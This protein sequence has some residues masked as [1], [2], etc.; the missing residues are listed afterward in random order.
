MRPLRLLSTALLPILATVAIEPAARACGCFTP[1]DPTVPIVQAGE[2]IVFAVSQSQVTAIIQIQYAGDAKDFGWLLPLPSLPTLEVSS[3][4]VFARIAGATAPSY[5]LE[6]DYQDQSCFFQNVDDGAPPGL[7]GGGGANGGEMSP[8][9]FQ[10]SVGPYDFAVLKADDK[11]AMLDWLSTNRYFVPVGT[12]D[13]V[14]PYLHAGAYFLALKL[15]SGQST[16]DLQPVVVRY[17][18]DLP[19][20]PI[21]LTSVTASPAMNVWAFL[22]GDGRAIPRNYHHAV[23]DDAALFWPL[24]GAPL[25]GNYEDVVLGAVQSAPGKHAFITE[26]AGS[27]HGLRDTVFPKNQFGD[28]VALRKLTDAGD[29]LRYLR[30]NSFSFTGQLVAILQRYIKQPPNLKSPN[31]PPMPVSP[32]NYYYNFDTWKTLDPQS[33]QGFDLSFDPALLTDELEAKIVTPTR[34]AA[35]LFSS[36]SYFTRLHSRIDP[37]DMD[38]DPVFSFNPFLP[39]VSNVHKAKM[40]VTCGGQFKSEPMGSLVTEQGYTVPYPYLRAPSPYPAVPPAQRIEILREAGSPEVVVDNDARIRAALA[41]APGTDLGV[42]PMPDMG[43]APMNGAMP[44][45]PPW[46]ACS[47]KPGSNRSGGIEV[48]LLLGVMIGALRRRRERG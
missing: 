1:P 34:A 31:G 44:P 9:V 23:L 8:L 45:T 14:A 39:D 35:T 24:Y 48:V 7:G 6:V 37:A 27:T 22:L 4:E 20:I 36:Q 21:T 15:K 11:T 3:D 16:G 18:S 25:P 17:A 41:V 40:T 33:F 42:E 29:Y 13:V 28:L 26:L 47:L 2:R 32:A 43:E 38:R 10:S 12:S 46:K 5:P 19:M 30:T